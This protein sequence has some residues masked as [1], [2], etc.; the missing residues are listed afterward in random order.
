MNAQRFLASL[1]RWIPQIPSLRIVDGSFSLAFVGV[2][3]LAVT[4]LVVT[5]CDTPTGR[6]EV[7]GEVSFNGTELK[8]GS[9]RLTLVGGEKLFSSGAMI[10]DGKY[11]I[12]REKGLWPGKY[13]VVIS[14]P[15]EDA[16]KVTVRDNSGRPSPPVAPELI[17]P[18]YNIDSQKTIEV[19]SDG[20]N[21]FEFDI[22]NAGAGSL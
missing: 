22:M 17:P 18:E 12:P 20:E 14:A 8:R 10:R 2:T 3:I 9:I 4:G 21:H 19:T 5:G 13:H 16:P 1:P 7:S 15:D 6:M 11:F